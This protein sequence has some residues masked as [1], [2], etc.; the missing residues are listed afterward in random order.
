MLFFVLT[1]TSCSDS[2]G[3]QGRKGEVFFVETDVEL[4]S[5]GSAV[6]AYTVQW[7]VIGDRMRGFLF[8]GNADCV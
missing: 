5:D 7:R 1:V 2:P 3:S 6:V 8:S 4:N